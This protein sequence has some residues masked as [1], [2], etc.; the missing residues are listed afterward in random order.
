MVGL[1]PALSALL[2]MACSNV[3]QPN[4]GFVSIEPLRAAYHPSEHVTVRIRNLGSTD[5]LISSCEVKLQGYS[6]GRWND[7]SGEVKPGEEILCPSTW[8]IVLPVG[9]FVETQAGPY[10]L[11]SVPSG[12]LYRFRFDGVSEKES[13][14]LL[15]VSSRFSQPFLVH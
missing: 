1:A 7:V 3:S 4:G 13:Q 2:A 6:E 10:P 8:D 5:L 15:P 12:G 14:E 9:S 11:P